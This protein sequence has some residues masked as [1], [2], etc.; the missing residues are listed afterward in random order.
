MA[1]VRSLFAAR[2][3]YPD[4]TTGRTAIV[5]IIQIPFLFVAMIPSAGIYQLV[6]GFAGKDLATTIFVLFTAGFT[7]LGT[8]LLGLF[9]RHLDGKMERIYRLDRFADD[10]GLGYELSARNTLASRPPLGMIFSIPGA[11]EVSVSQVIGGASPVPFRTGRIDLRLPTGGDGRKVTWTF[12]EIFLDR[13]LPH[14]VLDSRRNGSPGGALPATL[15]RTTELHL[16]GDF[17]TYFRTFGGSTA[18]RDALYVLTPDV[19]ALLIDNAPD[20]DVEIVGDRLYF[21]IPRQ[22]ELADPAWWAWVDAVLATVAAKVVRTAARSR[23]EPSVSRP[24][25]LRYLPR[26]VERTL[27]T[28]SVVLLLA[29]TATLVVAVLTQ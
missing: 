22:V 1:Q 13:P 25:Q 3:G 26:R 4:H 11:K 15:P 7:F 27:W 17:D 14:V 24:T 6:L 9:F 12:L 2:P 5:G 16:E 29:A 21:Y 20:A 8:P 18:T 23:F 28:A 10:N 19:M